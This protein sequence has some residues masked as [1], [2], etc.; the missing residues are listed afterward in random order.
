[1]V[2]AVH[3]MKIVND[4]DNQ[5]HIQYTVYVLCK[6]RPSNMLSQHYHDILGTIRAP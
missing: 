5:M 3:R 6:N 1:M 2:Y 4:Y